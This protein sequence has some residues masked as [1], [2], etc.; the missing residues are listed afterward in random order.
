MK[1][2]EFINEKNIIPAL[3]G[4]TKIDVIKE[5]LDHMHKLGV[6]SNYD[7]AL[8]DIL[9][10]ENHLSTGLENGIAIPHAKTDGVDKLA[11]VFGIKQ[12]GIDFESLDAQ[13]ANL[14][15][16]VLS[17]K[18]TSGPHIQALA[19]ISR[20]LS[21]NSN[22]ERLKSSKNRDEIAEILTSFI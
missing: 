1:F 3:S 15:F 22:R 16:L 2:S 13:P 7:I 11:I 18:N 21:I 6:V 10:R 17:P 8:N 9:V 4:E 20:N 14:I 5:L 12:N 19:L